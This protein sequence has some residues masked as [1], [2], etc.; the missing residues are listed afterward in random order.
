MEKYFLGEDANLNAKVK[1]VRNSI[2]VRMDQEDLGQDQ[3]IFHE[4]DFQSKKGEGKVY[5][6]DP[7]VD[8][9]H[10]RESKVLE[11]FPRSMLS[12]PVNKSESMK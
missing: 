10:L 8:Q 2:K 12:L 11:N 4:L 9:L 1:K 3:D 6:S 7:L 5:F